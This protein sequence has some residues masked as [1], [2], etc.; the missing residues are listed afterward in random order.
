MTSILLVDDHP[1]MRRGISLIVGDEP[2]LDV[3]FEAGTAEDALTLIGAQLPDLVITDVS[4]PG[5]SGI[6]LTKHLHSLHP[7]L[8]VLIISRHDESLYAERALRAGAKGYVM[9]LEASGTIVAA[10]R[11]ILRGGIY[12]SADVNDHLLGHIAGGRSVAASSPLELLSDRELDVFRKTGQGQT[13]HEI[14]ERLHLSIKTVESYRA[15]IKAKLNIGNAAELM[16][17][18]VTWV[19][20]GEDS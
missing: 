5:M 16:Q 8:P 3:A 14:A 6:E 18:A 17:Q 20:T 19:E 13:T 7:E 10:I 9:K 2:D 11:R 4:L 1:V 12:V 15:R